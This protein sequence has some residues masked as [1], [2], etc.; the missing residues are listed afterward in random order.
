MKKINFDS[1]SLL[2]LGVIGLTGVLG[3]MK[4]FDDKNKKEAETEAIVAEVME[5][6]NKQD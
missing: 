4:I 2:S 5:R 1:K 3:V 6:L